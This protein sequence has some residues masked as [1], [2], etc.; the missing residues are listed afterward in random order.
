MNK[1]QENTLLNILNKEKMPLSSDLGAEVATGPDELCITLHQWL[2][3]DRQLSVRQRCNA[4]RLLTCLLG[5]TWDRELLDMLLQALVDEDIEIRSC[6]FVLLAGLCEV[7]QLAV[8]GESPLEP[9][10]TEVVESLRE[11]FDR[12]LAENCMGFAREFLQKRQS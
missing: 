3:G 1:K 2:H 9:N 5:H 12:G 10:V 6:S 4:L 11:S 8:A 7:Q